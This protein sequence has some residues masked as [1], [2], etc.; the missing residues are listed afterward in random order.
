MNLSVEGLLNDLV[1]PNLYDQN[2]LNLHRLR[3]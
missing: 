1:T 3:V 2:M